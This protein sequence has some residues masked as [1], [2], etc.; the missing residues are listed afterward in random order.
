MLTEEF[1]FDAAIDYRAGNVRAALREHAPRG[2]DVFFD[3]VGGEILDAVLSRLARGS[4]SAAACRSMRRSRSAARP[5]T[6]S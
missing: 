5:I 4:Y 3:N 2:V 1:G 6:W